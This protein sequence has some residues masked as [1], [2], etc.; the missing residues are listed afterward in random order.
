MLQAFHLQS[1]CIL[2][3]LK[4]NIPLP[5]SNLNSHLS[6]LSFSLVTRL[7]NSRICLF[8]TDSKQR[9]RPLPFHP[10]NSTNIKKRQEG[11]CRFFVV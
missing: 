6:N 4:E 10:A 1:F 8:R 11:S 5:D 2:A 3:F 7:L 9:L